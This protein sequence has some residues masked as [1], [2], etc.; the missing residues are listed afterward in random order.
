MVCISEW[1]LGWLASACYCPGLSTILGNLLYPTSHL[2][3]KYSS[4]DMALYSEGASNEIYSVQLP[5]SLTGRTPKEVVYVCKQ[6]DLLVIAVQVHDTTLHFNPNSL[7]VQSLGEPTTVYILAGSRKGLKPLIHLSEERVQSLLIQAATSLSASTWLDSSA[8]EPK[9]VPEEEE[10]PLLAHSV[11]LKLPPIQRDIENHFVLCLL[12]NE[13]SPAVNLR[14][15]ASLLLQKD[16]SSHLVVVAKDTYLQKLMDGGH[17]INHHN[18]AVHYVTG[19]PL[20][21]TTLQQAR[22]AHCRSCALFTVNPNPDIEEPALWDKDAILCLRVLEGISHDNGGPIPVVVELLEESNVQF[23]SL[24]DEEE[25]EEEGEELHLSWPYAL[26]QVTTMGMLD[27]LLSASY[28]DTAG[29]SIAESLL[30][31]VCVTVEPVSALPQHMTTF[32]DA[33]SHFLTKGRL[34]VA[35]KRLQAGGS[36]GY[37]ANLSKYFPI[38][39]PRQEMTLRRVSDLLI[40]IT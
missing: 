22:V 18:N 21:V 37:T 36:D 12:T 32:G 1:R 2:G 15:F 10:L 40:V 17:T 20:E 24:E 19:S 7:R 34:C 14:T 38:T 26:G 27:V 28:F 11:P 8:I 3:K 6:L 13:K 23:V 30:K 31:S 9:H 4:E 25:E 16:H 5:K 39:A 35:V 29:T 33:F